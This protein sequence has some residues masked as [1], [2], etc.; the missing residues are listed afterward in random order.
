[1]TKDEILELARRAKIHSALMYAL[2]EKRIDALCDSE[3][4]ELECIE[5]FAHLIESAVIKRLAVGAG[6]PEIPAQHGFDRNAS[7]NA[8]EYVCECGAKDDEPCVAGYYTAEQVAAA[9]AAAI[10]KVQP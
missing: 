8:D 2:Y 9:V 1:M 10:Q 6:E 7:H 5:A 4:E 3:Q